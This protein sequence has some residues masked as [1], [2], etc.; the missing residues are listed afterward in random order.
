MAVQEGAGGGGRVAEAANLEERSRTEASRAA[1]EAK[2]WGGWG[3][4]WAGWDGVLSSKFSTVVVRISILSLVAPRAS[5][6]RQ[7]RGIMIASPS[8]N[9]ERE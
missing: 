4:G 2:S 1:I 8:E 6:V 3:G 7:R 5:R 9:S